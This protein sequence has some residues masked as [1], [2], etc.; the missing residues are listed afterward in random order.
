[1][2]KTALFIIALLGVSQAYAATDHYI[3]RDGGFVKH[4]KI[5]KVN[6]D[7][8]VSADVDYDS[9][10]SDTVEHCSAEVSG[11][12]KS[13][14]ATELAFKKHSEVDASFCELKIQLSPTGAKI[15]QGKDCSTFSPGK[16]SFSSDGKELLKVK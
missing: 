15:E 2:K 10:G 11:S 9:T 14:S 16:C 7:Y 12:A 1:M 6:D 3:L 13:V 4:L 8:S 5:T